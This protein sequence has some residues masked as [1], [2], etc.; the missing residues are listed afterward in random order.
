M[1]ANIWLRRYSSPIEAAGGDDITKM[2]CL[3]VVM[4]QAPLTWLESFGPDSIDS[5]HSLK[6]V[7][8]TNF[9]CSF[10]CS[11]NKY[12]HGSCKQKPDE[13]LHKYNR[14]FW[15]KKATCIPIP[16][17]EIIN[18]FQNGMNNHTLSFAT[19]VA[20]AR[21][22]WR[23]SATWWPNRWTLMIKRGTA[24]ASAPSPMTEKTMVIIAI[25]AAILSTTTA[26]TPGSVGSTT[27]CPPSSL[28]AAPRSPSK[29]R[30]IQ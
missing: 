28:F 18:M 29:G 1:V 17:A 6:K 11:G 7:S 12:E 15:V 27:P 10:E 21:K 23:S 4:E 30:G 5:W 24:M 2:L 13:S 3:P 16:N 9:H 19:S 8:V 25:E 14:R 26:A 20:V 22:T